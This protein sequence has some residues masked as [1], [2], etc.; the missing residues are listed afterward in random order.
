MSRPPHPAPAPAVH[1][2][3]PCSIDEHVPEQLL[4]SYGS[5]PLCTTPKTGSGVKGQGLCACEIGRHDV[6]G[7]GSTA[8]GCMCKVKVLS[9][10]VRQV[11]RHDVRVRLAGMTS[12]WKMV[13]HVPG[14]ATYLAATPPNRQTAKPQHV[15][16]DQIRSVCFL[17]FPHIQLS[18][19]REFG[20]VRKHTE[21][22]SLLL[23]TISHSMRRPW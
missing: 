1:L 16:S 10:C 4:G 9:T 14:P 8:K 23:H 19:L 22:G 15:E 21:F 17:T 12:F 20:K 7:Q 13:I 18:T 2:P 11:G 6:V 5:L 3:H